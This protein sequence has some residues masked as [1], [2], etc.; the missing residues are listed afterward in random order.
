ME[1]Y[2]AELRVGHVLSSHQCGFKHKENTREVFF[3]YFGASSPQV[4][5]KGSSPSS[6]SQSHTSTVMHTKLMEFLSVTLSKCVSLLPG[7]LGHFVRLALDLAGVL[8][9]VMHISPTEHHGRECAGKN[10]H[11]GLEATGAACAS[12]Q[13]Q[14]HTPGYELQPKAQKGLIQAYRVLDSAQQKG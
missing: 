13:G 6:N 9:L 8:H 11:T 12:M 4:Q 5:G 1:K 2:K 7:C 3:P 10:I 14:Q